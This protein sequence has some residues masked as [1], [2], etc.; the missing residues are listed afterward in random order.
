MPSDTLTP[1]NRTGSERATT[2]RASPPADLPRAPFQGCWTTLADWTKRTG[3]GWS[4]HHTPRPVGNQSLLP[5]SFPGRVTRFSRPSAIFRSYPSS[6]SR[7]SSLLTFDFDHSNRWTTSCCWT[8]P[9]FSSRNA[10][11]RSSSDR[12]GGGGDAPLAPSA[13]VVDPSSA[14]G[15]ASAPGSI[16]ASPCRSPVA[17]APVSARSSPDP[18][19]GPGREAG[20]P[21]SRPPRARW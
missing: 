15:S 14:T 8:R 11:T 20:S 21:G 2:R 16:P 5:G 7:E 18:A 4:R 12:T 17:S 10:R 13:V 19:P 3:A 6:S 9:P 1:A